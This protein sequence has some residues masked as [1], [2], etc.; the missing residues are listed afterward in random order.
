MA[1]LGAILAMQELGVNIP[2]QV[3]VVGFSNWQLSNLIKPRL[4]TVSQ[5]GFEMGQEAAEIVI[6]EIEAKTPPTQ[7]KKVVGTTLIERDTT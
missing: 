7:V 1:A 6:N 4:T 3:K 2:D 5:A